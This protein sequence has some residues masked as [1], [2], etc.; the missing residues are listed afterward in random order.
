MTSNR[1]ELGR[2]NCT[3]ASA[4]LRSKAHPSLGEPSFLLIRP[5]SSGQ[6]P[7]IKHGQLPRL[8][9]NH[10]VSSPVLQK[11]LSL[12]ARGFAPSLPKEREN[13]DDVRSKQQLRQACSWEEDSSC[14][15]PPLHLWCYG[16][17]KEASPLPAAGGEEWSEDRNHFLIR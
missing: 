5:P 10:R 3:P 11:L 13:S 17:M 9:S 16:E 12:A 14:H 1:E 6:E 15:A 7:P 4:R 8:V 2:R